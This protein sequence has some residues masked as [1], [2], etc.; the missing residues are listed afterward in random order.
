[1]TENVEDSTS[2][3]S[4]LYV[5]DDN[6]V[7]METQYMTVRVGSGCCAHTMK[8]VNFGVTLRDLLID[9]GYINVVST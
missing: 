2:T 4:V 1:M 7:A 3:E 5:T 9:K 8:G 6:L